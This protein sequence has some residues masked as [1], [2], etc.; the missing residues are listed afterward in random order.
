MHLKIYKKFG[1]LFLACLKKDVDHV[2][3]DFFYHY[4]FVYISVEVLWRWWFVVMSLL[5]NMGLV[6]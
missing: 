1:C 4:F 5:G 6:C 3:I 2:N